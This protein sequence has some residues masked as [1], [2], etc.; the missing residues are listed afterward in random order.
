MLFDAPAVAD[1]PGPGPFHGWYAFELCSYGAQETGGRLFAF[2]QPE[3]PRGVP[4][5]P[6]FGQDPAH[7]AVAWPST[8]RADEG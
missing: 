6:M 5:W 4:A 1:L 7:A 8:R 2:G 3:A